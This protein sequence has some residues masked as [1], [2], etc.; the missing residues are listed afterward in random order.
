MINQV[1]KSF[2]LKLLSFLLQSAL[3]NQFYK[4]INEGKQEEMKILQHLWF[5]PT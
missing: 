4:F 5:Y 2:I 3:N 1:Q